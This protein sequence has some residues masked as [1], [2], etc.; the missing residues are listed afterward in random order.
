MGTPK[1]FRVSGFPLRAFS[2]QVIGLIAGA[3]AIAAL[4]FAPSPG[5]ARFVWNVTASAPV[6]LY[7]IEHGA[8]KVGDRIAVLPSP[9]L[10]N[11]LETRGVLPKGKLLIKRVA[12]A[13]G[14]VVCR[15]GQAVTLN[16]RAMVM[17]RT[18]DSDGSTLPAWTGCITLTT[19][20][21][22]LLGD[23]ATSYDARY[24]GV[25]SSRTIVGRVVALIVAS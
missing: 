14:D 18:L 21:V 19:G 5:S 9:A 7:W 10:A 2:W 6:G 4:L 12:A 11:D 13:A 20:D 22:F 3:L 8:W 24:F 1:L 17:A 25:T 23:T 15:N 16:G